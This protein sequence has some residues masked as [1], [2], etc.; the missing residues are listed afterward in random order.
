MKLS[1]LFAL[2]FG[3]TEDDDRT[4]GGRFLLTLTDASVK[5]DF[6]RPREE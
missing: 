3:V 2:L 4:G 1:D 6:S 5:K